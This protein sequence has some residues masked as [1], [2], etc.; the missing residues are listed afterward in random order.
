[1]EGKGIYYYNERPFIGARYE[2]DWRNDKKE[3]KGIY[4]FFNGDRIM[5]DYSNNK[6]IGKH[7]VLTENVEVKIKNY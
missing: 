6:P 5:G 7:V 1:M 2:G 3:G 4:Y